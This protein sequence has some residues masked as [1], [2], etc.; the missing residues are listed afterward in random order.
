MVI[1][2]PQDQYIGF[3]GSELVVH[4]PDPRCWKLPPGQE[5]WKACMIR[6]YDNPVLRGGPVHGILNLM[7]CYGMQLLR[8]DSVRFRLAQGGCPDQVFARIWRDFVLPNAVV[9]EHIGISVPCSQPPT[10]QL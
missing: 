5:H 6:A 4:A 3:G 1:T 2:N 10:G 9:L 7:R 8:C